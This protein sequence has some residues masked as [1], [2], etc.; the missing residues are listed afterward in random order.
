M[1]KLLDIIFEFA[2]EWVAVMVIALVSIV[3]FI[4]SSLDYEIALKFI[5]S[6]SANRAMGNVILFTFAWTLIAQLIGWLVTEL[7]KLREE[8]NNRKAA[9]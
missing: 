9:E 4:A 7:R 2:N 3:V 8:M 5:E 1:K 6:E